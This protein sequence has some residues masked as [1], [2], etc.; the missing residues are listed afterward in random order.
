[1][2]LR[3][4]KFIF[5]S[6]LS[7]LLMRP[8][9]AQTGQSLL[10]VKPHKV[11]IVVTNHTKFPSRDDK[12]GLWLTELTH[13]YTPMKE[14][15][16]EVDIASPSGGVVPLD[17]R[18]LSWLYTDRE[19]DAYL[20][21]SAFMALLKSSKPAASVDPA[22]YVAVYFAGGHGAMW[23]FRGNAHL[24]RIAETIY[25]R[26][27]IV[28]SVC[29][30]AAA[31]ID[32]QTEDGLPLIRGRKITGFSNAEEKVTGLESQVPYS[33]QD[34][35]QTQGALYDKA[36]V[37]FKSFA[38]IDGRI[39]TG[40]NPWSAKAVAAA[41]LQVLREQASKPSSAASASANL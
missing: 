27:G 15:G 30:G 8:A 41:V 34:A 39:V 17:E 28:S 10:V 33:L 40:Q 6:L 38:L 19:A 4:L 26:G 11:L 16:L 14:A 12:T 5:V 23:D 9:A 13:F 32:L 7:L 20:A 3:A 2:S 25:R 31:L 21:D 36:W 35:L 29:H 22:E 37:P 18:S 24:K 1:M